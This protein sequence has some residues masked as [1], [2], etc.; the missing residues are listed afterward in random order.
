MNEK[1]VKK[2]LQSDTGVA[3]VEMM[4]RQLQQLGI[5]GV[6]FYI[7]DNKFGISG[8]QQPEAFIKAFEE[9]AQPASDSEE[10]CDVDNKNC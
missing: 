6:P 5:S 10:A 7:I 3:E 2:L 8:A 9:V 4:E 1:D